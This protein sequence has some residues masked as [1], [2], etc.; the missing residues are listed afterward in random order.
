MGDQWGLLVQV[1]YII[2]EEI[3]INQLKNQYIKLIINIIMNDNNIYNFNNLI[4]YK[5]FVLKFLLVLRHY[6]F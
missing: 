3:S 2:L 6:Y 5:D 4:I 1:K